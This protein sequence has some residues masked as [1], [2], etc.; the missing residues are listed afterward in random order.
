MMT[1]EIALPEDWTVGQAMATRALLQHAVL[2]AT[3]VIA[4]V[5]KD[6]TAE[7]LKEIYERVETLIREAGLQAT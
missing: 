3:P 7:Q 6:A 2:T 1:I 4:L 5:R